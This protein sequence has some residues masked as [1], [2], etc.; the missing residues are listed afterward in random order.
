MGTNVGITGG[1]A[2]AI[3]WGGIEFSPVGDASPKYELSD[4]NFE[5]KASGNGDI[6]SEAETVV[7]YFEHD[8][9]M[10]AST[11]AK[12]IVLKDGVSRSGSVTLINGDVLTLDCILDSEL[13]PENGVVTLKL[14]GNV[15]LQ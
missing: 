8:V 9:A 12:V 6:Y 7:K 11:Y 10:T 5:A 15:S 1:P 14:S 13:M 4:F 2:R 3:K